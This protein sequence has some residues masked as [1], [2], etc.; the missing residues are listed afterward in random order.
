MILLFL[1]YTLPAAY[2]SIIH[3][4]TQNIILLS[5]N[6]SNHKVCRLEYVQLEDNKSVL[7]LLICR[8]LTEHNPS[9]KL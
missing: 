2:P 9:N 6:L 4:H 5:R 7:E 3:H 1:Q 8:L